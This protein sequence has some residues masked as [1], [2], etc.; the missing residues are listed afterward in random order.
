[1][2]K[3]K[4]KKVLTKKSEILQEALKILSPTRVGHFDI[5]VSEKEE[6]ICNCIGQIINSEK[7]RYKVAKEILQQI[8]ERL[9]GETTLS[10]WLSLYNGID[11]DEM[12]ANR[13]RKL[14]E[15]RKQWVLS[16]IEEFKAQG[17]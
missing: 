12:K 13:G 7:V 11:W 2:Q 10:N 8:E 5:S 17:D 16:M 3:T 9:Q 4:P 1:M 14:Q 15:T 6:F